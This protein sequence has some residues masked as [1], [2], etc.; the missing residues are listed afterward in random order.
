MHLS[1]YRATVAALTVLAVSASV[2]GC[3]DPATTPPDT[4]LDYVAIGDSYTAAP[5][6]PVIS[7]DGCHR[8]DHNYP[9]LVARELDDVSLRDVSCGGAR[10]DAV[11]QSQRIQTENRVQPPQIGALDANT[12]IVTVGLGVNDEGFVVTAAF[13]CL[14]LA[15]RDP[16]GAPCEKANARKVPRLLEK[17]QDRYVE[18]LNAIIDRAPNARIIVVGDPR[19]LDE[20]GER[21]V[22]RLR[23]DGNVD[24]VRD[25]YDRF[26]ETIEA[27]AAEAGLEYVDVAAASEGH[28]ICSDDPWING[29]R[30]DETTGAA[31]YHPTPAEQEAVADLILDLLRRPLAS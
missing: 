8:S 27:A 6:I 4:G 13:G 15:E 30:D 20:T 9:Q 19:L 31:A 5:D 3:D 24:C 26:N 14:V 2:A 16:R 21:R 17:I 1:G 18:T 22:Q 23:A 7:T 28:D 10:T 25:S 11:L 29:K 12:D